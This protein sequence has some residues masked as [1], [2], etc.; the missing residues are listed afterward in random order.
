MDR[1]AGGG[2]PLPSVARV[3][4]PEGEE[5][6]GTG[7]NKKTHPL[8]PVSEVPVP[9]VVEPVGEM[10]HAEE[11]ETPPLKPASEV[12]V[13][14]VVEPVGGMGGTLAKRRRLG[15]PTAPTPVPG[16]SKMVKPPNHP[17]QLP[18]PRQTHEVKTNTAERQPDQRKPEPSMPVDDV[19]GLS[20]KTLVL[21]QYGDDTSEPEQEKNDT[22][23]GSSK[24]R[25]V[26]KKTKQ[27]P[28]EKAPVH[29]A[30]SKRWHDKWL[31]KGVPRDGDPKQASK[32]PSQKP[33]E[34]PSQKPSEKPSKKRSGKTSKKPDVPKETL[35]PVKEENMV[36]FKII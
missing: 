5:G 15:L 7:G 21:G 34:K 13:P 8:P 32:K 3:L 26:E 10:G 24:D 14:Q 27:T 18:K 1:A 4:F 12:P 9:K 30:A 19:D 16:E 6:R 20:Q 31:S 36:E 33:S 23:P 29:R 17:Q 28:E 11:E 2:Q 35:L 22:Q 25:R